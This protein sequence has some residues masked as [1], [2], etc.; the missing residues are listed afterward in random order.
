MLHKVKHVIESI[1]FLW[2]S[3]ETFEATRYA[4]GLIWH[5]LRSF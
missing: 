5:V 1:G 4:A 3:R 2:A